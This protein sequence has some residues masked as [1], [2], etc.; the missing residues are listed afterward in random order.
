MDIVLK[1]IVGVSMNKIAL[2]LVSLYVIGHPTLRS[3]LVMVTNH[4]LERN[5]LKNTILESIT[6][7]SVIPNKSAVSKF[8]VVFTLTKSKHQWRKF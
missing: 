1:S 8:N 7:K 6:P 5:F 2:Q 4:F 3:F